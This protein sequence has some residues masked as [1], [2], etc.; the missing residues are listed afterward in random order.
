MNSR[1]NFGLYPPEIREIPGPLTY[2]EAKR[3]YRMNADP[4]MID[5]ATKMKRLQLGIARKPSNPRGRS[6][7]QELAFYIGQ[8]YI[9]PKSQH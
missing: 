4:N 2:K 9:T 7:N 6:T 1:A 5:Y 3:K 8:N